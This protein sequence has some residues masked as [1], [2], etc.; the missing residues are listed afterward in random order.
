MGKKKLIKSTAK[1]KKVKSASGK[2]KAVKKKAVTKA[3][4]KKIT[5]SIPKE[6]SIKDLIFKK[7]DRWQPD[8]LYVVDRDAQFLQSYKATPF[9]AENTEE[10]KRIKKLLFLQFDLEVI[11]KQAAEKAAVKK[12]EEEK[13]A[14][15]KAEAEKIAAEKA[16]AEKAAAEKVAAEK[17]AAEKAAMEKIAAEKAAIKKAAEEKIAMEKAALAKAA[18]EKIAAEKAAEEK[19]ALEN[20]AD[21]KEVSKKITINIAE[22]SEHKYLTKEIISITACAGFIFLLL[23]FSSISNIKNY[24]IKPASTGIEIL[25]GDFAPMGNSQ[26]ITL[27]DWQSPDLIK[28]VYTKEEIFIV[29]M[30]R[31]EELL[32]STNTSDLEKIK[33]YITKALPLASN[34]DARKTAYKYIDTINMQIKNK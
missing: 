11:R 10:T 33:L 18:E 19:I 15:A 24:Y 25:K 12:A 30:D 28:D 27:M 4:A 13:A 31:V 16:A 9:F 29:I 23:I 21:K 7:F 5:S 2:K 17:A 32:N 14:L 20:T 22:K 6:I 34:K 1:T 8:K 3:A 26:I